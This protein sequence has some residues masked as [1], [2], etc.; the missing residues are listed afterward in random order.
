MQNTLAGHN[1]GSCAQRDLMM[2]C[3]LPDSIKGIAHDLDQTLV[4]LFFTPEETGEILHPFE[5]AD[6]DATGIGNHVWQYQNTFFVQDIVC[7]WRGWAIGAFDHH[8]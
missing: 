2:L 6:C 3:Y 1:K 8:P 7:R 5:V 4:D